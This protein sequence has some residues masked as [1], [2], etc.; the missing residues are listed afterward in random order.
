MAYNRGYNISFGPP[1]TPKV[2][3]LLIV[4]GAAFVL[5]YFPLQIFGWAYPYALFG[6]QPYAVTHDLFIWQLATYLF[7]HAGFF[8]IIFNLFV[9]WMFGP[10]LESL[11]GGKQFLFFY[12]FTGIGAGLVDVVLRPN[13]PVVTIGCSGALFGL[14]LAY[15]ALFPNRPIYMYFLIPIKAKW[16]VAIIGVIELLSVF[17]QGSSGVSHVAHLGGLLFGALYLLHYKS[18]ISSLSVSQRYDQWRRARRRKQFEV[19][20]RKQDK[21]NDPDRWIN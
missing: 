2:K 13:S 20:M 9:L 16:F 21:K 1:L 19:Y 3:W 15:G 17:G 12:F 4:T 11:W 6:L 8:H 10:D 5:T 14:M 18:H 7:L